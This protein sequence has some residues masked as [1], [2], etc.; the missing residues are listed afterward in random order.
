MYEIPITLRFRSGRSFRAVTFRPG[1]RGF[2]AF[3]KSVGYTELKAF[4]KR[5]ARAHFAGEREVVAILPRG[6]AKSTLAAH[7]ALHHVLTTPTPGVYI[8]AS[9]RDQA[10]V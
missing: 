7:L 5:I 10:R 2:Y 3:C 6:S 8:G 1:L 4:Q 9:S